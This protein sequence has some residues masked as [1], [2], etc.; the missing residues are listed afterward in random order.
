MTSDLLT[1]PEAAAMLNV[2]ERFVRRL[3]HERRIR[4]SKLGAHVRIA[5]SDLDAYVAAATVEPTFP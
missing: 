3:V 1:V 4:Y 2:G 5:R